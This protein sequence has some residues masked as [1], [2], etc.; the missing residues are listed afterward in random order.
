MAF[1]SDFYIEENIIGYTRSI[2]ERFPPSIYYHNRHQSTFG[3]ITLCHSR[4]DNIGRDPVI[5]AYDYLIFNSK[6][7][8]PI[9]QSSLILGTQPL[10]ISHEYLQEITTRCAMTANNCMIECFFFSHANVVKHTSRFPFRRV[11]IG[12][13]G[14]RAELSKMG[15][16]QKNLKPRFRSTLGQYLGEI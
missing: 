5:Q 4:P 10:M 12:K 8:D 15:K 2:T 13:N 16:K 6:D 1:R 7:E 11:I 3:C 14:I 9:Q